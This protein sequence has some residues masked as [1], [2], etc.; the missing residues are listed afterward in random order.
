MTR[1]P[2]TVVITGAAGGI[3]L[4]TVRLFNKHRW[5]VIAI[6]RDPVTEDAA[7]TLR[8]DLS[9][10]DAIARLARR[11]VRGHPAIHAVVNNAA[12]QIV[13]PLAATTPDDWDRI[14]AVNLRA[15]SL[16][17]SQLLPCLARGNGAVVNVSSVHA[18]ATSA[19]MAAYA[20][21]KGGL[22]ALTRAMALEFAPQG[23]R[24]NAVLPGA[25]ETAMLTAGL[26]RSHATLESLARRHPLGRV[27]QP[28]DIAEAI[29]FLADPSRAS[30][31]TGQNLV[32]DGG[33]TARLGTE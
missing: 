7:L 2:K 26:A 25:V 16:L 31:I 10:A 19:G 32:V 8:A 9:S 6:D 14:L 1:S 3:G 13:K 33:A 23:I 22:T 30:F 27:G 5:D 18:V 29:F 20:A 15:A 21:S 11:I 12:E 17:V 24:V 28:A 4:A